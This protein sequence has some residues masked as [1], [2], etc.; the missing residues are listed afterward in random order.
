MANSTHV[1]DLAFF[2]GGAPEKIS[3]YVG[4]KLDWHPNGSI[5]SGAGIT[6]NNTLFSYNANW[7]APGRWGVE[8]ITNKSRLILRP[9]E[10]LQIQK[11]GNLDPE[12]VQIYKQFPI[13][14]K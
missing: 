2:L 6:K 4:G 8:V 11:I 5:F 13:K 9:L 7:E 3:S 1:V 12:F 14:I 10:K